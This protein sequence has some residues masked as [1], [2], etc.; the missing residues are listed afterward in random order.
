[1]AVAPLVAL[2]EAGFD[3][4]AV[5]TNPDRRRGRGSHVAPSPVKQAALERSLTVVH[6]PSEA[7]DFGAELGVVVAYGQVLKRELLEK[8]PMVNLHFSLLPRW[9]GAAPVQ[10]AILAG[11]SRTGVCVMA[12]DVGLDTG[13]VFACEEIPID[14]E[15]TAAELS[16][17]LVAIGSE[18]LVT[19]L[20]SGLAEPQEQVGE[21]TYAAKLSSE[22]LHIDWSSTAVEINRQVRVGGA[23]TTFRGGRFKIVKARAIDPVEP[24]VAGKSVPGELVDGCVIT[25]EG[26]LQLLTIQP[27]GKGPIDFNAWRNGAQLGTVERFGEQT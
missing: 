6:D 14:E 7:L 16:D 1:M 3:I 17:Q 10:R 2:H 24:L 26:A 25:G 12:V 18:M 20:R 21:T 15:V 13:A 22:D 27:A 19:T 11:D 8:L 23:W 9:R 5:V 4:A